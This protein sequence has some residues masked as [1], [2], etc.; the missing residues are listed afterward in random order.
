M[1]ELGTEG[2]KLRSEKRVLLSQYNELKANFETAAAEVNF[3][4]EVSN[5][6][7]L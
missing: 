7:V 5:S 2:R 1:D 4:C 6:S 3:Y